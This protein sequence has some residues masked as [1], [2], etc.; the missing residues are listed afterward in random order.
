MRRPVRLQ[1]D[2]PYSSPHTRREK[3][4]PRRNANGGKGGG[5]GHKHHVTKQ[6][7]SNYKLRLEA[8]GLS[9][10]PVMKTCAQLGI[11]GAPARA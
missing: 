9:R 10:A 8:R 1:T 6:T 2:T 7:T 3:A 11:K 4:I 5:S